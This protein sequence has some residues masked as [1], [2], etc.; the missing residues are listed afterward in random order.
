MNGGEGY[1]EGNYIMRG[2]QY[3]G[4][5]KLETSEAII[6][7]SLNTPTPSRGVFVS[8]VP[9]VGLFHKRG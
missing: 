9:V 5:A 7:E 8:R 1:K 2:H 3:W 4:I 6:T